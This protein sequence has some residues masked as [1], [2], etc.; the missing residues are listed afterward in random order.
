MT[1]CWGVMCNSIGKIVWD[2]KKQNR[3]KTIL[4]VKIEQYS[5]GWGVRVR[6]KCMS[7]RCVILYHTKQRHAGYD[8]HIGGFDQWPRTYYHPDGRMCK[9]I[10]PL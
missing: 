6:N 5:K 7:K 9:S 8:S 1:L 3:T 10:T 2:W 4:F